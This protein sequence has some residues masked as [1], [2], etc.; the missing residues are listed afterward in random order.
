[1]S[2]RAALLLQREQ[3]RLRKADKCWGIETS[4]VKNDIFHWQATI[5]GLP[6]TPWE[7]GL[8]KIEMF[9]D[10]EY[11]EKPPEIY[12][13]TVPFHPNVDMN[14]GRP[15]VPFLEDSNEWDPETPILSI[16]VYLQAI[17]ANPGLDRPV[18]IAASEIYTSSPRLYDQLVRDCV[19]AS[20][21]INVGLA[22]FEEEEYLNQTS[23]DKELKTISPIIPAHSL[24]Q[25]Y[26]R[27]I[28]FDDYYEFWKSLA[29]SI[30][31]KPSKPGGP[32]IPDELMFPSQSKVSEDQFR[33]MMER[34]RDLWFGRFQRKAVQ[35]KPEQQSKTARIDAMRRIYSMKESDDS[36]SEQID[37]RRTQRVEETHWDGDSGHQIDMA[38]LGGESVLDDRWIKPKEHIHSDDW[39]READDLLNWTAQLAHPPSD[40]IT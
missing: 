39:E 9:F 34:Q 2:S 19:I 17:L 1:M 11:N 37:N 5:E 15:C 3:Y 23:S 13:M 33:E 25:P 6:N 21:R 4:I 10:E 18:N 24:T 26:I 8:F 27:T 32:R 36:K 7:G 14:T 28:S 38:P 40:H 30:P 29:T 22:P 12:F 31:Q 20:R 16:L 35:K